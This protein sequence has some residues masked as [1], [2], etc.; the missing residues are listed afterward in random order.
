MNLTINRI[1]YGKVCSS[2]KNIKFRGK[3]FM[4]NTQNFNT[5]DKNALYN[6]ALEFGRN[7]DFNNEIKFLLKALEKGSGEACIELCFNIMYKCAGYNYSKEA[8][9]ACKPSKFG[10]YI[11]LGISFG[12]LDCKFFKA[13]EQFIG[14][15]YIELD[16]QKAYQAFL[17]LKHLGYDPYDFFQDDWTI[18]DYIELVE[19]DL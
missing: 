7:G 18:D 15:G 5:L 14:D 3:L 8:L 13:R 16:P 11:D 4:T 19:K 10:A 1:V 17:E 6:L 2:Q 9:E 12:S